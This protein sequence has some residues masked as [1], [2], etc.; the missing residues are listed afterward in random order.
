MFRPL[1]AILR[2]IQYIISILKHL[3]ESY[4]YHNG[5]VV[6]KFVSYCIQGKSYYKGLL[7]NI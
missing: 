5:Y 7:T 1:R 4:R 3:R 6:H 2:R